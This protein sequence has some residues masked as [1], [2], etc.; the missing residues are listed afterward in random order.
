MEVV[1]EFFTDGEF[2]A[3]LIKVL[4]TA[5]LSAGVGLMGTLI[6]NVIS[7]HKDSKI[8]KYAKTC[9]KAAE[10][11]FPNEG[12]KMGPEKMAYVM[13]QMAI[14]FPKIKESTYFYNL[15]EAAVLELNRKIQE[16][17]AI[18]E[19]KEKYNENP[20]NPEENTPIGNDKENSPSDDND[21]KSTNEEILEVE[22]EESS[23]IAVQTQALVTVEDTSKKVASGKVKSF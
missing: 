6:G 3:I 13:D 11:K 14:K 20:L 18:E 5:L 1:T 4:V 2:W 9:V 19:F 16:D 8:Y 10:Q 22:E 12:K 7:K 17:K 23:S 15:A 21:E